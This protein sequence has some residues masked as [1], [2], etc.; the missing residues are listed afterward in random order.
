[1]F[2]GGRSLRATGEQ[3]FASSALGGADDSPEAEAAAEAEEELRLAIEGAGGLRAVVAGGR[4]AQALLADVGG[5]DPWRQL[6]RSIRL[7]PRY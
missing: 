2:S 6:L 1:M 5:P 4:G 7:G 3:V